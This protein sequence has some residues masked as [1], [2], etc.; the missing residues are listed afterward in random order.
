MR[1]ILRFLRDTLP[2][3]ALAMLVEILAGTALSQE[4]GLVSEKELLIMIPAILS[5]RGDLASSLASRLTTGYHLGLIEPFKLNVELLEN[6]KATLAL[7]LYLSFSRALIAQIF[8]IFLGIPS[9][10][11]KLLLFSTLVGVFGSLITMGITPLIVFSSARAGFDPDNVTIP[12][13][14]TVLD[15]VAA[16]LIAWGAR[17]V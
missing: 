2:I 16:V 13:L 9:N 3:I 5:S 12:A 17:V 1:K 14:A 10:F 7:T 11:L 15:L 6:L 8:C 4:E